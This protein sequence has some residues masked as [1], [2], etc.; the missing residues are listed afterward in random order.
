MS[1]TLLFVVRVLFLQ[2]GNQN[3]FCR[4]KR[5]DLFSLL[6]YCAKTLMLKN[7]AEK[8]FWE[9]GEK[10]TKNLIETQ[11]RV[12]KK[13]LRAIFRDMPRKILAVIKRKRAHFEYV[14]FCHFFLIKKIQSAY[15]FLLCNKYSNIV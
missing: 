15:N 1:S 6:F 12:P 7:L 11:A 8:H 10:L 5:T 3:F 4:T 2:H 14:V 9:K 13:E